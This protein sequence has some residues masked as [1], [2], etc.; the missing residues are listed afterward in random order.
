[1][2]AAVDAGPPLMVV[3]ADAGHLLMAVVADDRIDLLFG[4][5]DN[6]YA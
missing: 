2:V 1:M 3:V 6:G 4:R 5:R